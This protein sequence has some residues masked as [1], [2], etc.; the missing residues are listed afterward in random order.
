MN[1]SG[2]IGGKFSRVGVSFCPAR[3]E[4]Y[5]KIN[6]KKKYLGRFKTYTDAVKAREEAERQYGFHKNHGKIT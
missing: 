3:W 6:G 5:V 1:R 2:G 4:A